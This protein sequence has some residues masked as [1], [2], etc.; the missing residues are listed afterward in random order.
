MPDATRL[1]LGVVLTPI[2]ACLAMLATYL[3]VLTAAAFVSR[4]KRPPA[5]TRKRMFA[6]IVPAHDEAPV[7]GRLLESLS[8]QT[9][10]RDRYDVVVV[11]DNC[12]DAT[13]EVARAR[14]AIVHERSDARRAKGY[15]LAWMLERLFAERRYDAFVIFDADS[16]VD[17]DFLE[18]ANAHLA[19]GSTVVQGHYR[20]LDPDASRLTTLREAALASLHFVRPRGRSALGL[21]CGLKGNGMIFDGATLERH[22]WPDAGLAEDVELHLRLVANG[23]R[24]DFAP[25]AVVRAAMPTTYAQAETQNARW[26]AGRLRAMRGAAL[27]LLRDGLVAHDA[28]RIDAAI[29]QLIPPVSVAI[30]SSAAVLTLALVSGATSAAVIAAYATAGVMV[31]V[32]SGLVA[33]HAPRRTYVALALSAPYIVWKIGVYARAIIVRDN[34]PWVRTHRGA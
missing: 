22:G 16:V 26:E 6:V 3:L 13:A 30:A 32:V 5:D 14:H 10:P 25:D 9:Y 15:A 24:T 4:E 1:A 20:V 11:A 7:I 19:A 31:H 34:S 27:Q 17:G 28:M 2:A 21:S 8:A 12:A 29:E 18:R 33:V 23:V